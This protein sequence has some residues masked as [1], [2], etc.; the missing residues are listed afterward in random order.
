M[1]ESAST[2]R[3]RATFATYIAL[4]AA[5]TVVGPRELAVGW[6]YLA[7]ILGFT[8]VAIACLGR[9]WCSLFIA[10]HKDEVLVT[11]GPYAYCRH[12][13]YSFSIV[14]ALGLG[15]ASK[16]LLLC[17]GV[18]VVIAALVI[19]AASCEE[20]FLADAFPDEFKAYV[21]ATP[22]MWWPAG[23]KT[24]LPAQLDV[25]PAVFWKSF[26]DAGSFFVL[27]LLVALAAEYR[28]TPMF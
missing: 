4:V 18:L 22:N 2:P 20:Q 8:C 16:S 10:G 15:L 3:L 5:T 11:T 7:G 14:G 17:A 23:R 25:R 28:I 19:Y 27:Y 9:I 24:P 6:N 21:A 12:P 26:L 13:L 1:T